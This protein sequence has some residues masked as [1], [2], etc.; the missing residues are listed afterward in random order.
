MRMWSEHTED[1][2]TLTC[3]FRKGKL[4]RGK[5]DNC[6]APQFLL[7]KSLAPGC[8]QQIKAA[9]AKDGIGATLPSECEYQ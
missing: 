4:I 2:S 5:A 8:V 3:R 7:V 6:P 9:V 1:Q